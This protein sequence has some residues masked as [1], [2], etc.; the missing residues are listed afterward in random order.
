MTLDNHTKALKDSGRKALV[1]FLT[2]GYPNEEVFVETVKAASRAGCDVIEIGIPF[3]DPIADG[4]VIQESSTKALEQG[5]TLARCIEL[6]GALSSEITTPLVFMSYFNPIFRM[7]IDKF[8]KDAN[9]AGV[10]GV[11][12]PDVPLE[13]SEEIRSIADE[14]GLTYIDLLAPTSSDERIG[15]IAS[16]AGGFIY[17]VSVTGVTG[18]NSPEA[19]DIGR[20]VSRVRARTELPLY[21]GFGIASADQARSAC[22]SADGI[23][24]GSALIK[25]AQT[26]DAGEGPAKIEAFLRGVRSAIDNVADSGTPVEN[27]ERTE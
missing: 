9:A 8:A 19:G 4:P 25:M 3:S 23:I 6:A 16:E 7:G 20:F 27:T 15:A 12:V 10:S 22:E 26:G 14:F 5:I 11:I 18:A 24:I 2:A 17:L 13:E 1:A 21:V